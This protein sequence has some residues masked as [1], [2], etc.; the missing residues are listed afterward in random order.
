MPFSMVCCRSPYNGLDQKTFEINKTPD[1]IVYI[2]DLAAYNQ[3]EGL[4]LNE[5]EISY[6][7]E[8]SKNLGRKLTDSEVFGFS[9]VN[10]EHCWHKNFWRCFC[11]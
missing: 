8:L 4:A 5:D 2:D 6:L 1:P 9:Q 3:N 10:S 7:N 11:Y